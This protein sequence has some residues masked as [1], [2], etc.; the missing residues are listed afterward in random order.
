MELK[1]KREEAK[2]TRR[3]YDNW[4]RLIKGLLIKNHVREMY[5]TGRDSDE[6]DLDSKPV[7]PSTSGVKTKKDIRKEK[8]GKKHSKSKSKKIIKQEDLAT[9]RPEHV[10]EEKLELGIDLISDT[11]S[12][13]KESFKNAI[14]SRGLVKN[15]AICIDQEVVKFNNIVPK[16]EDLILDSDDELKETEEEKKANLKKIL[17][18]NDS[19]IG[20]APCL[21]D[22]SDAEHEGRHE[23]DISTSKSTNNEKSQLNNSK[24]KL[25]LSKGRRNVT[26]PCSSSD[27]SDFELAP[28]QKMTVQS[29]KASRK[30]PKVPKGRSTTTK[31]E[32]LSLRCSGR[33][34][35]AASATTAVSYRK[36]EDS[37]HDI[38]LDESDLEDKTYQPE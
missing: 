37:E 36:N 26:S 28:E 30:K 34:R 6:E 19:M 7:V 8:P 35:T 21:S 10:L 25:S 22:D 12:M 23:T 5:G 4:K 16:E 3:I 32:V 38:S 13:A 33:R 18:W 15:R 29:F 27:S 31:A 14:A 20:S 1:V 9:A 17:A 24:S 2:R 11:V